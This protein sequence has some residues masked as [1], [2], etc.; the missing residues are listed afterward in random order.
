MKI[1]KNDTVLILTGKDAG[2]TG[3]VI[4]AAPADN[5]I[6]VDGVNV[7]MKS[8]KARNAN[9]TSA[10]VKQVGAIDASNAMIVCPACNKATRVSYKIEGDKKIRIC[11]KCGASLDVAA[12]APKKAPAKK[13]TKKTAETATEEVKA[14]KKTTAKKTTA[15]KAE[16]TA[17][18][19]KATKKTSTKKAEATAEEVKTTKKT[20]T[21]KAEGETKTTAKKTT[22]KTEKAE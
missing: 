8:R 20:S 4:S 14:T 1:K 15:K 9:E 7:Q 10:I 12:A 21:K 18:E 19:V 11:K 3:K 2:K 22:K 17:E 16:G 6:K 13:S 5:K